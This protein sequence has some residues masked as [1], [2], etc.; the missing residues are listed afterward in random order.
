MTLPSWD[1]LSLCTMLHGLRRLRVLGLNRVVL[2]MN[3]FVNELAGMPDLLPALGVLGIADCAAASTL[4]ALRMQRPHLLIACNTSLLGNVISMQFFG[5]SALEHAAANYAVPLPGT[6][7]PTEQLVAQMTARRGEL[8]ARAMVRAWWAAQTAQGGILE[9]T[10][11]RH[12]LEAWARDLA[13]AVAPHEE[14]ARLLVGVWNGAVD[15]AMQI[16]LH[17]ETIQSTVRLLTSE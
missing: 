4:E 9:D 11:D 7:S 8:P 13:N 15:A 1:R 5:A 12:V 16:L 14:R 6:S 10:S 2:S 17:P 3:W